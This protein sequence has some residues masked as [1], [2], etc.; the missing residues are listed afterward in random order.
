[1]TEY[2]HEVDEL[3]DQLRQYIDRT[4]EEMV[5]HMAASVNGYPGL[6]ERMEGYKSAMEDMQAMLRDPR[7]QFHLGLARYIHAARETVRGA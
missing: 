6:A 2:R 4:T 5:E 1:M 7:H 3:A